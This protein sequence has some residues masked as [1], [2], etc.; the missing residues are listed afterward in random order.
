MR[1]EHAACQRPRGILYRTPAL[2]DGTVYG[3]DGNLGPAAIDADT[4]QRRWTQE[5]EPHLDRAAA[6]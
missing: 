1:S 3:N 5:H 2:S 6:L 4:G